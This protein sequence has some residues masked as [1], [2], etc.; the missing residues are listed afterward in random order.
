MLDTIKTFFN[1]KKKQRVRG[2][3]DYP[4]GT[5][6]P[7]VF[8]IIRQDIAGTTPIRNDDFLKLSPQQRKI[9][10]EQ[11]D[12]VEDEIFIAAAPDMERNFKLITDKKLQELGLS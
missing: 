10:L 5:Y 7:I 12:K 8:D 6:S 2:P 9:I 1:S 3:E 4:D 11:V